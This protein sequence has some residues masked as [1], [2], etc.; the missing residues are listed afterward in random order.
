METLLL[1]YG[2]LREPLLSFSSRQIE[3]LNSFLSLVPFSEDILY[4]TEVAR[5]K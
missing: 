4:C 1:S 2:C 5:M 3:Y